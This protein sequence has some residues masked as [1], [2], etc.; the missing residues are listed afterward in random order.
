M[1][2]IHK[3]QTQANTNDLVI[4]WELSTQKIMRL[5]DQTLELRLKMRNS[6]A[7][8]QFSDFLLIDSLTSNLEQF[9]A[10]QAI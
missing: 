8:G 6:V 7:D 10:I 9:K 2:P 5:L 4:A 3:P 1:K